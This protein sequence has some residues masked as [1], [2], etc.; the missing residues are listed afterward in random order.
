MYY[1]RNVRWRCGSWE[2]RDVRSSKRLEEAA[3]LERDEVCGHD[4]GENLYSPRSYSLDGCRPRVQHSALGT[5]W[6]PGQ[7]RTPSGDEHVHVLCRSSQ[8]A[9]QREEHDTGK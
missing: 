5:T 9:A 2:R 4:G 1:M 3:V 7:G 8:C 6:M